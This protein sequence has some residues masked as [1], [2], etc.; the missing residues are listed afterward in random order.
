MKRAFLLLSF[1]PTLG[2]CTMENDYYG[3]YYQP[4]QV[5]VQ[6]PYTEVHRHYRDAP[7]PRSYRN[8]GH[9]QREV[10]VPVPAPQRHGHSYSSPNSRVHGHDSRINENIHSQNR[11]A[12]TRVHGHD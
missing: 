12:N 11:E 10:V 7:P 4:P 5:S 2:A 6:T 8:H 9:R 3:D 1:L